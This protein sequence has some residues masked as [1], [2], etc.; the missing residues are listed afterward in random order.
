MLEQKYYTCKSDYA[1]KEV[2]LNTRNV[3]LLKALLEKILKV[4][5][6]DIDIRN[7]ERNSGNVNLRRKYLDCLLKTNIGN[8][9]IEINS[10]ATKEYVAYR[11]F[12]Y[13]CD[14]YSSEVKKG[15]EYNK[16]IQFVQINLDYNIP[17]YKHGD[18]V[19][20]YWMQTNKCKKFVDNVR[21]ISLDM[22]MYK[23][24]WLNKDV[25]AI[26]ENKLLIMLDL[27][28]DELLKLSKGDRVVFEYMK[29]LNRVNQDPDFREYMTK[30]EDNAKIRNTEINGAMRKGI[31][32]GIT[33]G[34]TQGENKMK[35]GIA[36]NLF[37]MD[38][39]LED[40]SK[41]TGLSQEEINNILKS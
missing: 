35:I 37:A 36:R 5:I 13:L 27:E 4:K 7:V 8:I 17:K 20:E 29:E 1:F 30:E 12:A 21:I 9:G 23:K 3:D 40:I 6:S 15:E 14:M 31:A 32:Q 39:K 10:D 34:I 16:D 18:I 25:K 11:N 41:A 2:F 24:M 38:M 26:E 28:Q 22:E 33:Q 19:N